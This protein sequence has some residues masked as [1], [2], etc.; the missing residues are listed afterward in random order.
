MKI[1]LKAMREVCRM[2]ALWTAGV[3]IPESDLQHKA[4]L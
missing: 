4:C 2:H 3:I 1:V